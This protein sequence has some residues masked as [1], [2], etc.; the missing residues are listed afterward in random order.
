[1]KAASLHSLVQ[2]EVSEEERRLLELALRLEEKGLN[3]EAHH[4]YWDVLAINP[5]SQAAQAALRRLKGE[6]T[7]VGVVPSPVSESQVEAVANPPPLAPRR[8]TERI[9]LPSRLVESRAA[10]VRE[11][12]PAPAP[13]IQ[14]A[15]LTD[16]LEAVDPARRRR[17]AIVLA[18]VVLSF[19]GLIVMVWDTRREL[20][21]LSTELRERHPVPPAAMGPQTIPLAFRPATAIEY[22]API[23]GVVVTQAA[24]GKVVQSGDLVAE[25]MNAEDH[26]R[27]IAA[28]AKHRRLWHRARKNPSLEPEVQRARAIALRLLTKAHV[29]QVRAAQ[30]GITRPLAEHRIVEA[31]ELLI[32]LDDPSTLS[33]ELPPLPGIDVTSTCR[34]DGEASDQ[35]CR[36]LFEQDAGG[37]HIR[38][39]L[40]NESGRF[41]PNQIVAVQVA[42]RRS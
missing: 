2:E 35:S 4:A 21:S 13:E 15:S 16:D 22:E 14:I 3:A 5:R 37:E 25:I 28:R 23:G 40:P 26:S 10:P 7:V 41:A 17:A 33:A 19:V 34:F 20:T 8:Q 29:T 32:R 24:E 42:T 38:V 11:A 39:L 31:G 1:M 12:R 36:L 27:L 18:V 9:R 6:V 30:R